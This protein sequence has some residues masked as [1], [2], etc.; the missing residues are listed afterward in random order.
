LSVMLDPL[1]VATTGIRIPRM[2]S[3]MERWI[4]TCRRELL[5]RTL[6]WNQSHLL[7]ALRQFETFCGPGMFEGWCGVLGPPHH[8][9]RAARTG[10]KG[11]PAGPAGGQIPDTAA[12]R[13]RFRTGWPPERHHNRRLLTGQIPAQPAPSG[14]ARAGA[15]RAGPVPVPD[16]RS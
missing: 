1:K 12:A 11:P 4:Q 2:N 7:H 16:P 6:I 10:G 5:D 14:T 3:L 9:G 15:V 8:G 13:F